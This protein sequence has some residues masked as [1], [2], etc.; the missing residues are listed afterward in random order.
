VAEGQQSPREKR[1]E[2]VRKR[3]SPE[4][5]RAEIVRAA[6]ELFSETGFDG[7]TREVARRAGV[8]QP[9]LY[10]YFPDKQSLIEAVYRRVFLETWNPAW[11]SM[12]QD[13]SRPVVDRFQAFY[14]A[15][16]EVVFQPVWL[17][18]W[19]YVL[20][21]DAEVHAWYRE[22]VQEQILKPLVRE[23]RAELGQGD[24]FSVTVDELDVPWLLHGGL[25]NYGL[26]QA[27]SPD[28]SHDRT[29]IIQKALD[30]Y[31]QQS[32]TTAPT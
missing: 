17:R 20:L 14:E 5:R 2:P 22:V 30:L 8:K 26:R 15:Y 23:R 28:A 21:R 12:L 4:A 16:T 31:M 19:Y 18:L 27:T 10:R 9:L 1:A 11:D 7:S 25:L 24:R 32:A 6:V 29:A 3:L 13:R